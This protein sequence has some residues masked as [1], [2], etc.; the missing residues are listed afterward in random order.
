MKYYVPLP[1][2][3]DRAVKACADLIHA[4]H[5]K[6]VIGLSG[7]ADSCALTALLSVLRDRGSL[8][9][10]HAVHICHNIRKD[11]EK[12]VQVSMEIARICGCSFERKDIFP[13]PSLGN[14]YDQCRILRYKALGEA[15]AGRGCS[16]V[17]VAHHLNDQMETMIFRISRGCVA[18]SLMGML[19]DRE[20][21]P[22]IS[23]IRPLLNC[24]REDCER[25]CKKMNFEWVNDPSNENTNKTRAFIRHKIVPMFRE[26]N[27][28]IEVSIGRLADNLRKYS[29][30]SHE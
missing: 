17:A 4:R 7:G 30:G 16:A 3:R 15:A 20:L 6:I 13:D 27:P 22:S 11:C 23:L 1:V 25:I 24:T 9:D 8:L 26:L 29:K 2:R 10:L 28:R 19:P 12:D 5:R 14:M 21:L 18:E